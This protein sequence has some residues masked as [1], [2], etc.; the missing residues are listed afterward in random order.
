MSLTWEEIAVMDEAAL[1]TAIDQHIYGYAW[2]SV[3]H[4]DGE[5]GDW[6]QC[7]DE[8]NVLVTRSS[9]PYFHHTASWERT[10]ILAWR[11]RIG[12]VPA[13]GSI[14]TWL[15]MPMV[16]TPEYIEFTDPQEAR[17]SICR[18]ALWRALQDKEAP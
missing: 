16:G 18:L 8:P 4:E 10:M 2:H 13:L 12:I 1:N 15:I 14:R 5:R 7:T 6:W 11:Y 9:V 3:Q 17:M